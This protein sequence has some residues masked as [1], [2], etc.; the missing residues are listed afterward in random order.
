MTALECTYRPPDSVPRNDYDVTNDLN[1]WLRDVPD[2]ATISVPA[3]DPY[4]CNEPVRLK[5]RT[6]IRFDPDGPLQI[7]RTGESDDRNRSHFS[8]EGCVACDVAVEVW[9]T[10]DGGADGR[11]VAAREA[12]HGIAVLGSAFVA[13]RGSVVGVYGD[14]LYVGQTSDRN[15]SKVVRAS[16]LWVERVGR[17][18]VSFT[19]AED[20][21]IEESVIG[22]VRR[23]VWDLEPSGSQPDLQ[24]WHVDVAAMRNCIIGAHRLNTMSVTG[25]V[26]NAVMTGCWSVSR[27][28]FARVRKHPSWGH[29]PS[30]IAIT[31]HQGHGQAKTAEQCVVWASAMDGLTVVGN[32]QDCTA[33]R[34][35]W[36]V[37]AQAVKDAI[38]AYNT[39]E[40]LV[41]QVRT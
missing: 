20:A 33:D 34:N 26:S 14:G 18:G 11:Y 21:T 10:Y 27:P 13:I 2:H 30:D 31:K 1:A 39:G 29:R 4:V 24:G 35:M 16:K 19:S 28:L 12:Q 41:G 5:G 38:V 9:G 17:Q 3:G 15:P 23:T 40:N 8:V 22:D 6:G 25:A 7:R 37:Y 36:F 32:D